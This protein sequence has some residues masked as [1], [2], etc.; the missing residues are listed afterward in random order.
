MRCVGHVAVLAATFL[1]AD[2]D[3]AF[4]GA[5]QIR[6][7]SSQPRDPGAHAAGRCTSA[8]SSP[9]LRAAAMSLFPKGSGVSGAVSIEKGKITVEL[10]SILDN[11]DPFVLDT[12][13]ARVP[14]KIIGRTV[15]YNEGKLPREE[16][17]RIAAIGDEMRADGK[18]SAIASGPNKHVFNAALAPYLARGDTWSKLPWYLGETYVYHRL[19]DAVGYFEG[20]A[21]GAGFD[22]FAAEKE[23]ALQ[24]ALPLAAARAAACKAAVGEW[25]AA[26]FRGMLHMAL[27]GNQGDSS[28]FTVSDLSGKGEGAD[29]SRLLVDDTS[30]IWNHLATRPGG[31]VHFFNDNSGMEL[32][33][34]L[35]LARFLLSTPAVGRVT[36]HLKPYPFFVSDATKND[37]RR[38]VDVLAASSDP[39]QRGAPPSRRSAHSS[40]SAVALLPSRRS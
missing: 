33:S 34:D 18:L 25:C 16:L 30:D 1:A 27:W 14:T 24:Q 19:L 39:N 29:A 38:T 28:L 8:R 6:W 20:G 37:F 2:A 36:L 23:E 3:A 4:V 26:R 12:M 5:P 22:V 13:T 10:P 32:I 11:A 21:P 17:D 40:S 9:G 7:A 31:E 35:A 15:E